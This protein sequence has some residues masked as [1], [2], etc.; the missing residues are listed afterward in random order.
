MI[1]THARSG[2]IDA[3]I[4]LL[5]AIKLVISAKSWHNR[6]GVI[7]IPQNLINIKV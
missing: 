3:D 6:N 7:M 5:H 4:A 1:P 2:D